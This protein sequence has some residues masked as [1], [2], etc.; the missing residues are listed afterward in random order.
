M[1]QGENLEQMKMKEKTSGFQEDQAAKPWPKYNCIYTDT[2][3]L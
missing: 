1:T 2:C 3:G